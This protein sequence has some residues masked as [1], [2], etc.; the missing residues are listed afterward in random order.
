MTEP[1]DVVVS[2]EKIEELMAER[3]AAAR[4][5]VEKAEPAAPEVDAPAVEPV[6][7][8]PDAKAAEKATEEKPQEEVAAEQKNPAV[9]V[10]RK[11]KKRSRQ[12]PRLE[13]SR[14]RQSPAEA[15]HP[16]RIR[17]PPTR[18]SRPN[19][20]TKCHRSKSRSRQGGVSRPGAGS[21]WR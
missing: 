5:T 2:F 12:R 13:K 1:G 10:P 17:R 4:D 18:P 3:R 19:L 20:E 15:A 11:L 8:I 16:R 14:R 9:A 6:D 21:R 7:P